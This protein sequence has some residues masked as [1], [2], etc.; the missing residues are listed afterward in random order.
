[1][2][3]SSSNRDTSKARID[4]VISKDMW[5]KKCVIKVSNTKPVRLMF[6]E[7]PR[8]V[9]FIGDLFGLRKAGWHIEIFERALKDLN[10]INNTE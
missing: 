2:D 8:G 9:N 10:E 7:W 6:Y 4:A 3:E 1:M 5:L